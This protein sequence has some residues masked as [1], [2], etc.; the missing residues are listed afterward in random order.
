MS[1]LLKWRALKSKRSQIHHAAQ[2]DH[3]EKFE[4]KMFSVQ[5]SGHAC[6]RDLPFAAIVRHAQ[7]INKVSMESVSTTK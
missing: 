1:S 5:I 7:Q 6:H 4:S 2:K 3:I